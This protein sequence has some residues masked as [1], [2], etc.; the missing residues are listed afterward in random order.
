MSHRKDDPK[1]EDNKRKRLEKAE[2]RGDMSYDTTSDYT[3]VK[4]ERLRYMQSE[5]DRLK[6]ELASTDAEIGG[7]KDKLELAHSDVRRLQ[8]VLKERS[9]TIERCVAD[10]AVANHVIGENAGEIAMWKRY[11]R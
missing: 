7:L 1:G 5:M 8:G 6:A 10:L 9:A 3:M 4:T 2:A 11:E